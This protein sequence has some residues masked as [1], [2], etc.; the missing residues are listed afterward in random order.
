[1]LAA[2]LDQRDPTSTSLGADGIRLEGTIACT[3]TVDYPSIT[4]EVSEG[5]GGRAVGSASISLPKCG[6][7][8]SRW[9]MT[10]AS[11]NGIP[12][13]ADRV[14]LSAGATD[15]FYTEYVGESIG[16]VTEELPTREVVVAG[17][18]GPDAGPDSN[19]GQPTWSIV[20][21]LSIIAA[22]GWTRLIA[23]IRGRERR[24]VQY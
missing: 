19:S 14:T 2:P 13:T 5:F 11:S 12:F 1:V 8:P 18:S 20:V 22:V 24:H 4:G 10:A 23:L 16:N 7:E 21:V 9:Q 17:G 15:A 6:P 3:Q